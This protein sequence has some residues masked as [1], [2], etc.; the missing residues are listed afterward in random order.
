MI[1]SV[2]NLQSEICDLKSATEDFALGCAC[3]PKCGSLCEPYNILYRAAIV[4]KYLA[5]ADPPG[6]GKILLRDVEKFCADTSSSQ[7]SSR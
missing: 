2:F 1:W 4:I 6:T 3:F 7:P 5:Y